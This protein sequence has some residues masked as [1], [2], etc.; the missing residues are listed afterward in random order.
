MS[1]ALSHALSLGLFFFISIYLSNITS[2]ICTSFLHIIH[3]LPLCL[4]LFLLSHKQ[5]LCLCC[6]LSEEGKEREK[7]LCPARTAISP[8]KKRRTS[9]PLSHTF[10]HHTLQEEQL[11]VSAAV[12]YYTACSDFSLVLCLS[13]SIML[14]SHSLSISIALEK[15]IVGCER[16]GTDHVPH[17]TS[18]AAWRQTAFYPSLSIMFLCIFVRQHFA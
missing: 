1:A 4:S 7:D 18:K 3:W 12:L 11:F 9:P 5:P 10:S 13:H 2:Q 6:C 8:L 16:R 17:P 14:S 15:A